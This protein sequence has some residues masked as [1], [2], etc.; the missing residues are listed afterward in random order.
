MSSFSTRWLYYNVKLRISDQ[1]QQ[2]CRETVEYST[3]CYNYR[4]FKNLLGLEH[5]VLIL[6]PKMFTVFSKCRKCNHRLPVE[7][8]RWDN[9]DICNRICLL[10]DI[11]EMN[12]YHYLFTCT[13]FKRERDTLLPTYFTVRPNIYYLLLS[14]RTV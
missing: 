2:T 5:Y 14:I 9:I 12:E 1:F 13:Y 4:I 3:K 8:G 11:N 7:T 10:C 6:L